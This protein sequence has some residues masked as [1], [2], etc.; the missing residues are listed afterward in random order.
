M[1]GVVFPSGLVMARHAA[2]GPVAAAGLVGLAP[3]T[4][5]SC[6]AG[7]RAGVAGDVAGHRRRMGRTLALLASAVVLR[8]LGGLGAVLGVTA[9]W[10]DP[11]AVWAS[12]VLPLAGFE[13]RC[14]TTG[15]RTTVR[16]RRSSTA[17]GGPGPGSPAR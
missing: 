12:W 9:P 3:G 1:L 4:A 13:I 17:P 7:I 15:R 10:Y 16:P 6:A 8:A 5:G 14:V 11:A 2:A